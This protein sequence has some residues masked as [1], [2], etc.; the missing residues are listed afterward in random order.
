[1][2]LTRLLMVCPLLVALLAAPVAAAAPSA[3]EAAAQLNSLF[4]GPGVVFRGP[5]NCVSDTAADPFEDPAALVYC[6][7]KDPFGALGGP[8]A[9]GPADAF[10]PA[11]NRFE[12]SQPLDCGA[13]VPA[14]DGTDDGCPVVTGSA[15]LLRNGLPVRLFGVCA[16]TVAK[17]CAV[18]GTIT[19][20]D[21]RPDG[22]FMLMDPAAVD[23]HCQYAQDAGRNGCTE[24][25]AYTVGQPRPS[26]AEQPS[27]PQCEFG[28][29]ERGQMLAAYTRYCGAHTKDC[30][31]N[32]LEA[33]WNP[34]SVL[35]I[36]YLARGDQ[37]WDCA[38][39]RIKAQRF[40][41]AVNAR[42]GMQLPLV[43]TYLDVAKGWVVFADSAVGCSPPAA[44]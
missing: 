6:A 29:D 40:A 8:S 44:G 7:V 2:R 34:H 31:E 5:E 30:L 37:R 38:A 9:G 42:W 10:V 25:N 27:D 23:V 32:Q 19:D 1:M 43:L 41:D 15:T 20:P 24:N 16:K 21:W 35:A 39:S 17:D 33:Q 3:D 13:T 26:C 12:F 18:L 22:V 11:P 14:G 28:A 4:D 36:G